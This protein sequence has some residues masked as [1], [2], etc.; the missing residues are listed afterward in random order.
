MTRVMVG[1]AATAEG[2]GIYRAL[3]F[4]ESSHPAMRLPIPR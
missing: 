2:S 3:G 1:P 4:T